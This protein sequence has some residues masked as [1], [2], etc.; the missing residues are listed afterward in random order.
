LTTEILCFRPV[1][2]SQIRTNYRSEFSHALEPWVGKSVISA[3]QQ[4]QAGGEMGPQVSAGEMLWNVIKY[5]V[6]PR[7]NVPTFSEIPDLVM[8]F[9]MPRQ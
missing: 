8:I 7:F 6:K 2:S 3:T 5:T 1:Q 9:F 4:Q